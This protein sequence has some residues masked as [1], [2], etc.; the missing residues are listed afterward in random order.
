MRLWP[1]YCP[2]QVTM[3]SLS[4]TMKAG[5]IAKWLKKEG[6][7]LKPGDALADVETDKVGPHLQLCRCHAL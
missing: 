4:P 5:T 1:I 3:P 7:V 6:D 2:L